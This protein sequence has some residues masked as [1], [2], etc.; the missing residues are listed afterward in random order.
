MESNRRRAAL[1]YG[2]SI[3]KNVVDFSKKILDVY[4][5]PDTLLSRVNYLCVAGEITHFATDYAD[6]P[7]SKEDSVFLNIKR[8]YVWLYKCP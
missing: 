5:N 6:M 4:K 7:L 2:D 1:L 8:K 3:Q